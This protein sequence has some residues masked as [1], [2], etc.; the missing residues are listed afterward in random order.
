MSFTI[1]DM[2]RDDLGDLTALVRTWVRK[3]GCVIE[4][5]VDSIMLRLDD[6]L[7]GRIAGVYLVARNDE[8]RVVGVM[9]FGAL[10]ER[11]NSFR[12]TPH[13]KAAGLATAFLSPG[14]RGQGLGTTLLTKLF[15]R[16]AEGGW[17]EIIWSSNPRYRETAWQFYTGIAGEPV[18]EI[19]GFFGPGTKTPIWRRRLQR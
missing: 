14:C 9:G 15:S 13:A 16:A 4:E 6:H 11:M 12:S 1:T 18:G 10:D 3:D 17:V 7:E 2:T 5:E 19:D 8:G